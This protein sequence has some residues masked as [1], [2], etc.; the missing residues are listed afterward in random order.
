[1]PPCC[2]RMIRFGNGIGQIGAF[3]NYLS[4]GFLWTPSGGNPENDSGCPP[5]K[6]HHTTTNGSLFRTPPTMFS[7]LARR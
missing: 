6:G 5:T 2:A 4:Y 7:S 3:H 1:L